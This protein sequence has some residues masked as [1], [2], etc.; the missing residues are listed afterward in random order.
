MPLRTNGSENDIRCH[1]TRCRLA[2]P[3]AKAVPLL[4][5]LVLAKAQAWRP[6]RS[7]RRPPVAVLLVLE[8]LRPPFTVADPQAALRGNTPGVLPLFQNL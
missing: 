7:R 1:V 4:S 5:E 6:N 8:A 2:V 3:G